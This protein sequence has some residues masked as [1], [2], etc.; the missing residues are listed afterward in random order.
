MKIGLMGRSQLLRNHPLLVTDIYDNQH[1]FSIIQGGPRKFTHSYLLKLLQV[2]QILLIILKT[3]SGITYVL[4]N[5]FASK[6]Y[7]MLITSS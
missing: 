6:F 7:R 5:I 3:K 1:H 2:A 4:I